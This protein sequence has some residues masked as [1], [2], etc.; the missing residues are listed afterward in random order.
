V[1]DEIDHVVAIL[2]Q[3][4]DRRLCNEDR[5]RYNDMLR[6]IATARGERGDE[7][8]AY[9]GQTRS[10]ELVA[11]LKAEGIGEM[12]CRGEVPPYRAP[13]AYDNGAYRDWQAGVGF[14]AQKFHEDLDAIDRYHPRPDFLV[15]PD[16]PT[17][18]IESLEYSNGWL[19]RLKGIA[20]L[21]LCAQDG[22][23]PSDITVA[24]D[25]YAGLMVGGTIQWKV[26][27]S[28]AWVVLAHNAGK[29]CHIGRVGVADRVRWAREI[30]ADSIDSCFPLWRAKGW[31]SN[32]EV[33]L[34]ALRGEHDPPRLPPIGNALPRLRA[35]VAS[36]Q[37]EHRSDCPAE[38]DPRKGCVC[39]LGAQP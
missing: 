9:V 28:P 4:R 18:G 3:R 38:T 21:Y 32:L 15:V 1:S 11:R 14:D 20:P 26:R 31:D 24:I 37:L 33:F 12:T 17:R 10:R 13:W 23:Q 19:R 29:P 22:M 16:K 25:E 8:K 2:E 27:T 5:L 30:G 34:R 6:E 36:T 35:G 39:L 7:V